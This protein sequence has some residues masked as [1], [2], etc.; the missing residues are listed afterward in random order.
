MKRGS[1]IFEQGTK[2]KVGYDSKMNFW[3]DKWLAIGNVRSMIEGPLRRDEEQWMVRDV[4]VGGRWDLT[5]CSFVLLRE[6]HV[7]VE[8]C[9]FS[10]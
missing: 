9:S 7:D 8:S 5:R 10:F 6:D 1:G 4:Q 3:C 2:W